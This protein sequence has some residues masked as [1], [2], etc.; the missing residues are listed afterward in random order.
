LVSLS[1]EHADVTV[2]TAAKAMAMRES[3]I[4]GSLREWGAT[5]R[6]ALLFV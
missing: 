5:S 1:D 4:V 6:R 2:H 3:C